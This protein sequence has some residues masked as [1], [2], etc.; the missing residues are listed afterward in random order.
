MLDDAQNK[1]NV[2]WR[3]KMEKASAFIVWQGWMNDFKKCYILRM[4][5]GP[6]NY[7]KRRKCLGC[8]TWMDERLKKWGRKC[9][10]LPHFILWMTSW[11]VF[12]KRWKKM[13][14]KELGSR[15]TL[16]VL[17]PKP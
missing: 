11:L 12:K 8:V 9:P 14:E 5:E 17:N 3:I 6:K 2:K 13:K 1:E 10:C 4:D 16:Q 15:Q 7:G